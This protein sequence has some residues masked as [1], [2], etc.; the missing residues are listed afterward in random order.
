MATEQLYNAKLF[1]QFKS[2]G[3]TNMN[4]D[5]LELSTPAVQALHRRGLKTLQD[6]TSKT[7]SEIAMLPGL[8]Q[9][10]FRLLQAALLDHKLNFKRKEVA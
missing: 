4:L 10:S 2:L 1:G 6:I 9:K 7:E 5:E 3:E 8:G